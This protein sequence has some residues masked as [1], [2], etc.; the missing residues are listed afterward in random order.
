M[1]LTRES[2]D[3]NLIH[4]WETGRVLVGNKWLTGSLI[5]APDR[6]VADW[7]VGDP[8]EIGREHLEAAIDLEPEIILLGTGAKMLV[9][10]PG[11]IA[12]LAELA[13]GLEPGQRQK[14]HG[15]PDATKFY[16]V[17]EGRARF[18]TGA[19]EQH[20]GPGGLAWAAPGEEHGVENDSS[21]RVVLLV[22]MGPNPNVG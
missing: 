10:D 4:A 18:L 22:A 20:L 7:Q 21:E 19:T 6:I 13:I 17:I 2:S 12:S 14:P 1:Q 5:V 9:P 15:H 3:A 16:Y 8:S 11:L